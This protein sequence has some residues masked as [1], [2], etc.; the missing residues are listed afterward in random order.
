MS[1]SLFVLHISFAGIWLGCVLT[2]TLFER[3]LLGK[4]KEQDLILVEL[5][6]KVD[7]FVNSGLLCGIHDRYSAVSRIGRGYFSVG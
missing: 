5:H 6:K 4:G 2:E 1:M 3:A 7:L